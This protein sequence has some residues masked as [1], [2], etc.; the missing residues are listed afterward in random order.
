MGEGQTEKSFSRAAQSSWSVKIWEQPGLWCWVFLLRCSPLIFYEPTF[1]KAFLPDTKLQQLSLLLQH[2]P[3]IITLRYSVSIQSAKIFCFQ[4]LILWG[5]V[6]SHRGKSLI[7]RFPASLWEKP[8]LLGPD[9]NPFWSSAN[10]N[11]GVK[12][13]TV[14]FCENVRCTCTNSFQNAAQKQSLMITNQMLSSTIQ[15]YHDQVCLILMH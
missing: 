15:D 5:R 9:Y 10:P 8:A 11:Q 7:S 13:Y 3:F 4:V 1:H 2:L 12:K 14:W 6:I